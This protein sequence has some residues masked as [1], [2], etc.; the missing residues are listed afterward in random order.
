MRL[1]LVISSLSSGGA[2]RVMSTIAN[3]WAAKGHQIT[4]ITVESE[5]L[6]FYPLHPEVARTAL[7][8]EAAS[9]GLW[10]ALRNNLARLRLLRRK[11]LDSKP[12]TVLSFID[13]TNVLTLLACL[14][15][16]VPVVVSERTDPRY[17]GIGRIWSLLRRLLYPAAKAVVVQS[18]GVRGWA[19]HFV[20]PERVAVIPNPIQPP[21]GGTRAGLPPSTRRV[22]AMGRLSDEKR[23]DLLIRAF[24]RC[25]SRHPEWSLIIF[26]EGDE[27]GRLE[28][29]VAEMGLL[30]WVTLPGRTKE[31]VTALRQ[32]DLFVMS[33]RYEGF[34]NALL[35]AMACGLPV[36]STDCPS[37]PREIIRNGID[38]W[39]V[40]PGDVEALSAAM[41]RL[42]SDENERRRLGTRAVEVLERFGLEKAM[43]QWEEVLLRGR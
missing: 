33:S 10:E 23:F 39:L 35:E 27:R 5:R 9:A 6:D 19:E 34:P 18:E 32:A 15:T 37:G 4:L 28:A 16:R 14:G 13:K 20:P 26:G 41:D 38:G 31:P 1:T 2:E 29:L 8:L 24:G 42:M 7:G 30:G 40:P 12:D 43:R 22:M 25:Q 11:I 17:H 21:P 36:I 3:Y